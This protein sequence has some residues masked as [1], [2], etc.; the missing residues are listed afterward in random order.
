MC[1][2]LAVA[3]VLGRTRKYY[4]AGATIA[5][6]TAA[7]GSIVTSALDPKEI[8]TLLVYLSTV[9]LLASLL[10][11]L[12][13][14]VVVAIASTASVL[15]APLLAPGLAFTSVYNVLIFV[16]IMSV[17]ILVSAAVHQQDLERIEDQSRRANDLYKQ[18]ELHAEE[19]Q[20]VKNR[21]ES[22]LN[23][24]GDGLIVISPDGY[25]QQVNPAFEKM[26]GY[27]SHELELRHYRDFMLT[28]RISPV[29]KEDAKEAMRHGRAWHGEASILRQDGTTFDAAV[30][31]APVR[32]GAGEVISFTCSLRDIS[33]LKEVE[34]MKDAFVSNV[35]HELRTP[36]ASLK[37]YFDL[38]DMVDPERRAEVVDTLRR[39]TERLH[40]IIEGVLRLSRL[41]QEQTALHLGAVDLN[42]L[43]EQYVTDRIPLADSKGLS[44]S[45]ER[46][47]NLPPVQVDE[48]LLGQVLG[49]LLTNA[50]NYT[51]RG[52][53]IVVA[54]HAQ[55]GNKTGTPGTG[56]GL[57]IAKEIVDRH[58]GEIEVESKSGPDS[59][60]TFIVWMP[61]GE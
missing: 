10:L 3:Y 7:V 17:L 31:I 55:R 53:Q 40:L 27:S 21:V 20:R 12:R 23:S 30:T 46:E 48:G 60:T 14:T 19:L 34:R 15:L 56:L 59:G 54:T 39:E 57:A 26:I 18:A 58:G 1:A 6:L 8:D 35:S 5:L 38:L 9:V 4:T 32:N 52:G 43:V 25:I 47:P 13:G 37:I 22:I 24:V 45:L 49:I 42:V 44:L 36:I 41:D 50:L 33:E 51:P 2:L 29:V 61:C 28:S 11:P 16:V